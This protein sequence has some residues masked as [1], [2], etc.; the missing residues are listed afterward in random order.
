MV[1]PV[2]L[3]FA[4][5]KVNLTQKEH[6]LALPI[7]MLVVAA[8]TLIAGIGPFL[9][10][11]LSKLWNDPNNEMPRPPHTVTKW[12]API[13]SVCLVGL[14]WWFMSL[15]IYKNKALYTVPGALIGLCIIVRS[16]E[17]CRRQDYPDPREAQ[18]YNRLEKSLECLAG[19]TAFLF[20]ALESLALESY[21]SGNREAQ[22]RLSPPMATSF[23]ACVIGALSML[24]ATIPPS[25]LSVSTL[26]AAFD[27]VLGA[28]VS[29]VMFFMMYALMEL[30]AFI[31]MAPAFLIFL[32]YVVYVAND[33]YNDAPPNDDEENP[34]A[35][36][37]ANQDEP[38]ASLE[39]I[40]VT[41]VGFLAVS[42]PSISDGSVDRCTEWFIHLAAAAI[43]SGLMWRLL[44]HLKSADGIPKAVVNLAS[45]LTHLCIVIAVIPFAIM[46]GKALPAP[47]P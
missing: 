22:R 16:V 34:G 15:I 6:G 7:F 8:V 26:T 23:Y 32:A 31:L 33:N 13:C 27:V 41:F 1:S 40:K 19:I 20:L 39:L 21:I 14:A 3:A 24:L 9:A 47:S 2:L 25:S 35:V 38:P 11:S 45:I 29:L 12:L 46:A 18:D 30:R 28:A 43:V 4:L 10:F 17:Y 37:G 36:N 5:T 42:I 44:T